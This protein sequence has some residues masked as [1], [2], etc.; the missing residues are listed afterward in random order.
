M[1][2]RTRLRYLIALS[3][4]F[5]VTMALALAFFGA[6]PFVYTSLYRGP[7]G[8]RITYG[9][10]L[11]HVYF[12]MFG[13]P[14]LP[15]VGNALLEVMN[16]AIP[17]LGVAVLA[18]GVVRFA[19]LF[20]AR[21]HND[22]EWFE[23]IS[24]SMSGHVIVCGAGR[25]GY[26]VAQQL[27]E[28]GHELVVIEKRGDAPFVNILRDAEVAVLIDDVKN[29]QTL[30]RANVRRAS[31]I[32]CATDDDLAN[33]NSALDAR[34]E[35]PAIRVVMRLF[36]DDLGAR[37]RDSF[38]CEVLSTSAVAAPALALSALDPRIVHSFQVSGA[39]MVVARFVVAK[40]LATLT[41]GELTERHGA[42]VLSCVRKGCT[43]MHPRMGERLEVGD[44]L[45]LQSTWRHYRALREFTGEVR[46][47]SVP[48]V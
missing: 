27:R 18:D 6:L 37:V 17:P 7:G 11:H 46:A 16:F 24:E 48:D 39:L 21:R 38:K 19:Y 5:R 35:N 43:E 40:A 33:L 23:L 13:Q 14:S 34:K 32:V 4:R 12:L 20:F 2:R 26:R 44:V 25:I 8:A 9:E 41:V 3:R 47:P 22:R 31:A 15:Y 45:M 29:P 1:K 10:A 30:L 36:D 28:L 42:L